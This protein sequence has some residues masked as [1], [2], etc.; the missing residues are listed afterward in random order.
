MW[1]SELVKVGHFMKYCYLTAYALTF[2][3]C[4]ALRWTSDYPF[5]SSMIRAGLLALSI[6][7]LIL[8]LCFL[9]LS[10]IM[11]KGFRAYISSL[12][13]LNDVALFGVSVALFIQEVLMFRSL[14]DMKGPINGPGWDSDGKFNPRLYY[15]YSK[16]ESY[17][18]V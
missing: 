4:C 13:N 7:I 18:R 14:N 17:M 11:A 8:A 1:D 3:T 5:E 6:T 16:E 10:Q 12:W 2:L 9:E 15:V